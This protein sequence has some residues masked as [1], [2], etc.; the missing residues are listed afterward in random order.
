MLTALILGLLLP[1]APASVMDPPGL[2]SPRPAS[3]TE[4]SRAVGGVCEGFLGTMC[5]QHHSQPMA[6]QTFHSI[7]LKAF[8]SFIST[9][10]P[11]TVGAILQARKTDGVGPE[12]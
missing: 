10:M 12:R 5:S 7:D 4:S 9:G 2:L 3:A 11:E 1:I 8:T 6:L